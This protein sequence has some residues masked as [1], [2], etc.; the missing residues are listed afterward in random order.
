VVHEGEAIPVPA[1]LTGVAAA[2]VPEAFI[3]AHDALFTQCHLREGDRVLVHAAASGVGTAAVQLAKTAGAQ[4]IGTTRS[5]AKVERVRALGADVVLQPEGDWTG[6]V[7]DAT[8]GHG[9]DVVLDLV[10]GPYLEG[11][12]RVLARRGR[13]I[14]VGLTGGREAKLDM[15]LVLRNRLHLIGTVLR[16]RSLDEKITVATAFTRDVFP[17]LAV[18]AVVPV[19]DQVLP[20]W[21]AAEAQ[22][23]LEQNATVGKVVLAVS[24]A[25]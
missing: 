3:T 9:V 20:L 16:A 12:V 1:H 24:G 7:L 19:V 21:R 11:N 2:A 4:V 8:G 14:I 17:L 6:G 22:R 13:L 5:A 23:I 15:G 25:D 18:D 10:G